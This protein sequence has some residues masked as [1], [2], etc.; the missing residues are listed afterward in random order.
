MNTTKKIFIILILAFIM[1]FLISN[2]LKPFLPNAF[3]PNIIL[4]FVIFLSFNETNIFGLV[5]SFFLG[6]LLDIS[7][8]TLLGPWSASFVIIYTM[9]AILSGRIF[10]D[11]TISL[12]IITAISSIICDIVYTVL[13]FTF[14]ANTNNFSFDILIGSIVTAI[15][16]PFIVYILRK[17]YPIKNR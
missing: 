17:Y 9:F 15:F 5:L 13:I 6:L 12:I 3:I 7:T 16:S 10:I 8:S 1:L 14:L 2:I 11:T 4:I